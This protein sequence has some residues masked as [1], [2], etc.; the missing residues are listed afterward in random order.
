MDTFLSISIFLIILFVYIHIYHHLTISNKY[1]IHNIPVVTKENIDNISQLRQP[2]LF[3]YNNLS[4]IETLHLDTPN[5]FKSH[6]MNMREE[7]ES[8]IERIHIPNTNLNTKEKCI[9][10]NNN[11]FLTTTNLIQNLKDNDYLL[12]PPNSYS[13]HYDFIIGLNQSHTPL[14]YKL[15][16]KNYFMV[17]EG[18]IHMKL[19][20]PKYLIDLNP[21]DD[22]TNFEF[23]SKINPW[24]Y[25]EDN[26]VFLEVELQKGD[27]IYIPPY[28]LYSIYF[29]KNASLCY[30]GY[31]TIMSLITI[32]PQLLQ[33]LYKYYLKTTSIVL[34]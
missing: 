33:Y 32:S 14:Q 18:I 34:L 2:A 15:N 25:V 3:T 29:A 5:L 7:L 20:A 19:A 17:T 11:D 9:L 27:V 13:Q 31:N 22:Y 26:I 4:I 24:T 6:I 10:E 23:K 12:K 21:I 8:D 28:W 16:Y 30:F 1:Q